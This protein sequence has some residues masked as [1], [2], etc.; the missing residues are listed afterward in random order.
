MLN[1]HCNFSHYEWFQCGHFGSWIAVPCHCIYI[2]S[3]KD[4]YARHRRMAEKTPETIVIQLVDFGIA[5]E[6]GSVLQLLLI[7]LDNV[8]G[9]V[10]EPVGLGVS[11]V[12]IGKM[13]DSKP[14]T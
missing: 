1:Y 11:G 10:G 2:S 7:L 3:Q 4:V 14:G 5:P 8:G 12:G 9:S 13:G 6:T